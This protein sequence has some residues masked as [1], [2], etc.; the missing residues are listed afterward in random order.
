ME[1]KESRS[2][3]R[4]SSG[5]GVDLS[6]LADSDEQVFEFMKIVDLVTRF[7]I[8]F[9]VPSKRPDDDL[10]V[11]DLVWIDWAGPMNHLIFNNGGEF[12]GELGEL[13]D[14]HGIRQFSRH[15]KLPRGVDLLNAMAEF[16]EGNQRCWGSRFRGN[17]KIH[18]NGELGKE[19][20]HQLVWILACLMGHRSRI[21]VAVVASG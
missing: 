15:P 6:V 17:A 16:D 3:L 20:P 21:Q 14:A 4:V 18:L 10:S 19:R 7:N 13:M 1:P 5:V 12:E 2:E 8:C 9:P 11:L